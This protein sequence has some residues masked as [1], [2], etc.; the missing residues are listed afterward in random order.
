MENNKDLMDANC[1]PWTSSENETQQLL[2]DFLLKQYSTTGKLEDVCF[3]PMQKRVVEYRIKHSEIFSC[4]VGDISVSDFIKNNSSFR[5]QLKDIPGFGNVPFDWSQVVVHGISLTT[6]KNDLPVPIGIRIHAMPQTKQ[7]MDGF[8]IYGAFSKRIE[9]YCPEKRV[10]GQDGVILKTSNAQS[11]DNRH[12][13]ILFDTIGTTVPDQLWNGIVHLPPF[14]N[15]TL[16]CIVPRRHMLEL[17][18]RQYEPLVLIPDN[19]SE[20][21]KRP[22]GWFVPHHVVQ[23]LIDD[24]SKRLYPNCQKYNLPEIQIELAPFDGFDSSVLEEAALFFADKKKETSSSLLEEKGTIKID[25]LLTFSG[26]PHGFDTRKDVICTYE[27]NDGRV[28]DAE[29]E[30]EYYNDEASE[31]SSSQ[32]RMNA[33]NN[34]NMSRKR[35]Y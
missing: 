30:P 24:A 16:W 15:N 26:Y 22:H 10:F 7:M 23:N 28:D 3:I 27:P 4:V 6:I 19:A 31:S 21:Y 35:V 12:S 1:C 5:I 20:N 2:C 8:D 18:V 9:A 11:F 34:G 14:S 25:F 32:K 13:T 29:L 17:Q 33:D